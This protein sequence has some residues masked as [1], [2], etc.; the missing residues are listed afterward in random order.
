MVA[1]I[2]FSALGGSL[3]RL[4]NGWHWSDGTPEPAVRD[5]L[6]ADLAPNFR[7]I[8]GG[9]GRA[10]VEIPE[11]WRDARWWPGRRVDPDAAVAIDQLIEAVSVP[12]AIY[13]DG[14]AEMADNHRATRRGWRV[15]VPQWDA[16]MREPCGVRWDTEDEPRI[17]AR[18]RQRGWNG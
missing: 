4:A 17:L 12:A 14:L 16:A 9:S 11:M 3:Q 13:A 8:T 7:C 18:A 1:A 5:M 15:P 2:L 10:Y 6:L